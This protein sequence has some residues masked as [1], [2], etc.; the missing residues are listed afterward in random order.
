MMGDHAQAL[1]QYRDRM[2]Q[3]RE[4]EDR[5]GEYVQAIEEFGLDRPGAAQQPVQ[6]RAGLLTPAE[7]RAQAE[8]LSRQLETLLYQAAADRETVLTGILRQCK[9]L[10]EYRAMRQTYIDSI[11]AAV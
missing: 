9:N 10:A 7:I 11:D 1:W 3:A 5:L 2:R 8:Q 6:C 4:T